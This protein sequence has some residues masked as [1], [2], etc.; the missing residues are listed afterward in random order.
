MFP[1]RRRRVGGVRGG[2]GGGGGG[3][4]QRYPILMYLGSR[5]ENGRLLLKHAKANGPNCNGC[6]LLNSKGGGGGGVAGEVVSQ[7]QP[8]SPLKRL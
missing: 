8:P 7:H 6:C 4:A 1:Y 2:G 3:G 5:F